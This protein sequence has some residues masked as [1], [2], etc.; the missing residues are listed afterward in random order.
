MFLFW[1]QNPEI[2]VYNCRDAYER[3]RA[4]EL[5]SI[6]PRRE[7]YDRREDYPRRDDRRDEYDRRDERRDDRRDEYERRE[8]RDEGHHHVEYFTERW[9]I[10]SKSLY[11]ILWSCGK[12][13]FSSMCETGK[14]LVYFKFGKHCNCDSLFFVAKEVTESMVTCGPIEI[15]AT[16]E[17]YIL[18]VPL[19]ASGWA[20]ALLGS[21]RGSAPARARAP[22]IQG[23]LAGLRSLDCPAKGRQGEV[24]TVCS[25]PVL[26]NWSAVAMFLRK[27]RCLQGSSDLSSCQLEHC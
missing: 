26:S 27:G 11:D 23:A 25:Q 10:F 22:D 6:S 14:G 16:H 9:G 12:L 3:R 15:S 7:M 2:M 4:D 19:G 13:G 5:R 17:T 18:Q 8:R 20:R 24:R 21:R 1:L